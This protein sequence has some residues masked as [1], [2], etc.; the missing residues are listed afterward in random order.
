MTT[1]TT[2]RKMLE[3]HL[4]NAE[5][6]MRKKGGEVISRVE[7]ALRSLEYG[8]TINSLG[9]IEQSGAQFDAACGR[10]AE[11]QAIIRDLDKLEK[12]K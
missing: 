9:E 10:Y 6:A 1:A 8:R 4:E 11:T 7:S 3:Q 2:I 5:Y 12:G